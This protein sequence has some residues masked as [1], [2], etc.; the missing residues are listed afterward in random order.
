MT[1]HGDV[2]GAE[3]ETSS[4]NGTNSATFAGGLEH[5]RRGFA[6]NAP[7][8][9]EVGGPADDAG[10]TPGLASR[11]EDDQREGYQVRY[12]EDAGHGVRRQPSGGHRGH[13]GHRT[14]V[15][16]SA[17]AGHRGPGTATF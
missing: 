2:R 13:G 14:S 5:D 1:V 7:Q 8:G 3:F 10:H 15:P 12:E 11:E 4:P 6:R 9:D 17:R 16:T